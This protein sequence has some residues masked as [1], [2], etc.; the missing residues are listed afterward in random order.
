MIVSGTP[1]TKELK[2]TFSTIMNQLGAKQL[3]YLKQIGI[4]GPR[5]E[6]PKAAEAPKVNFQSVAEQN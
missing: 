6:A 2:S 1:T 5:P 3:D 4:Q